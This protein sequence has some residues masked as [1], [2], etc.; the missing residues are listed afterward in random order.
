LTLWHGGN[1]TACAEKCQRGFTNDSSDWGDRD[2]PGRIQP[3][4]RRL[5]GG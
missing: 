2:H 3:A 4:S 5:A 1:K